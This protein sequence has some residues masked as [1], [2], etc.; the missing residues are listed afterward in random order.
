MMMGDGEIRM[1]AVQ[2][3]GWRERKAVKWDQPISNVSDLSIFI[4]WD[5]YLSEPHRPGTPASVLGYATKDRTTITVSFS[6]GWIR[7]ITDDDF[8]KGLVF[9][10]VKTKD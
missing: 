3:R 6:R 5:V 9:Y 4:G 1:F 10:P 2:L 8:R 7:Y